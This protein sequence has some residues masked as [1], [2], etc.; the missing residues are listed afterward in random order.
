M[1]L[2]HR[3]YRQV[4]LAKATNIER[5][6][7]SNYLNGKYKPKAKNVLLI[8]DVLKV[9]VPWLLGDEEVPMEIDPNVEYYVSEDDVNR[10]AYLKLE[11][12]DAVEMNISK[13]EWCALYDEYDTIPEKFKADI[14][15]YIYLIFA[16]AEMLKK[17][18]EE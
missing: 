7:I 17:K 6:T 11:Y 18:E 13:E 12:S 15:K 14:L 5:G 3:G 9:N 4:D 16:M 8:A 10:R 2:K 1:A